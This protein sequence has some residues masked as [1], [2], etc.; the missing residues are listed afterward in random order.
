MKNVNLNSLKVFLVVATSNSFL[1]ASNKLYISQPAISKTINKLEEEL[2]LTLFYRANKGISLTTSGEIL[3]KY[4]RDTQKVLLT[5]ERMLLSNNDKTKG[6]IAIGVQSHIVRNFLIDK[7]ANFSK[8]YPDVHFKIIDLSTL[9]MIDALEK[10]ELDIV[11]GA[12]P[13]N[14]PY[15]NLKIIPIANLNT[16]FIKSKNNNT[17]IEKLSDLSNQK[18]ILPVSNSSLRQNLDNKCKEKGIELKPIIECVTEEVIISAVKKDIAFGYVIEG[19]FVETNKDTI[20]TIKLNEELP[21]VEVNLIYLEN[22]ITEVAKNFISAQL[23]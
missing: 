18:L 5:C 19:E 15:N 22:N 12:S 21:S 4:V 17:E 20:E 11:I 3:L 6:T 10:H 16:C 1:E 13:I 14:S 2:G 9:S 23:L 8:N 7:I